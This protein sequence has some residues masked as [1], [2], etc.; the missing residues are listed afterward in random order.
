MCFKRQCIAMA[1]IAIMLF[2][3]VGS[4]V[5][6][7]TNS[8]DSVDF[9]WKYEMDVDPTDVG[10]IN[11]DA[12][13]NSNT[14]ADWIN[15]GSVPVSID[16]VNGRMM[17]DNATLQSGDS[18][19]NL[20]TNVG[21]TGAEGFT[22]EIKMTA[23]PVST[24]DIAGF[25]IGLCDN[26]GEFGYMTVQQN[27]IKFYQGGAWTTFSTTSNSDEDHVF[28]FARNADADG[29]G[30]WLW[31]DS[32]PLNTTVSVPGT[33][34]IPNKIYFGPGI[35][36]SWNGTLDVDYLRLTEGAYQP[37]GPTYEVPTVTKAANAFD[38]IYDMDVDPTDPLAIDLDD[39]DIAD[40]VTSAGPPVTVDGNGILTIQD[41][42]T[43]RS[44]VAGEG[45]WPSQSFTAADGFTFEVSME[46]DKNTGATYANTFVIA[47][48]DSDEAVAFFV[49]DD[50]IQWGTSTLA[51]GEDNT[52]GQHVYRIARDSD[53][54]GGRWW[55]WRDGELL[56]ENGLAATSVVAD[57][58]AIYFGP[59]VSGASAGTVLIDYVALT[60]G[61]YAPVPEPGTL[62]LLLTAALGLLLVRRK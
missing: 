24:A 5:G 57:T 28:R 3:S 18:P 52:D 38:L 34:N 39:D 20:W 16:G 9:D 43:F 49:G 1:T 42:A 35:S 59:G 7:I 15:S 12:A 37:I 10:A 26:A 4:A 22:I 44:G 60:D 30:W 61:S 19:D 13:I 58:D 2:A 8:L 62:V 17:M 56:S 47:L 23:N 48:S 53:Y 54:D 25:I 50:S 21:F 31:R 41:N 32:E 36:G 33:T 51:P 11:L 45:I 27:G 6:Q 46:V 14:S 55:M 29:G 40:W